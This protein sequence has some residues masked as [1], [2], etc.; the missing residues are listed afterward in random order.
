MKHLLSACKISQCDKK[1]VIQVIL[2]WFEIDRTDYI[3]YCTKI[4]HFITV[5]SPPRMAVE[6]TCARSQTCIPT[7]VRYMTWFTGKQYENNVAV[8]SMSQFS[9]PNSSWVV[10]YKFRSIKILQIV[11]LTC[12]ADS[13][14][15]PCTSEN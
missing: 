6:T 12:N 14:T 10:C 5:P 15:K 11:Y 9:S 4:S 13:R 7:C 2:T 3:S 8:S 1:L